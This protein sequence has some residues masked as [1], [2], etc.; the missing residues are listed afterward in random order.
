MHRALESQ[1][2][3]YHC[4]FYSP[5]LEYFPPALIA[6]RK[7]AAPIVH[8]APDHAVMYTPT[9]STLVLTFHNYY[10]DPEVQAYSTLAQRVHYRTDLRLLTKLAVRRANIVTAVSQFIADIVRDDL[11]FAGGIRVIPNG[12]DLARFKANRSP[13]EGIRVLFCGNLSARKGADLLKPISS[14][15]DSGIEIWVASGLRGAASSYDFGPNV[16]LIGRI[17]YDEMPALYNETDIFLAPTRR[18]GF[19]LGVA[20]AMASGLPVVATNCSALPELVTPSLGGYLVEPN[21]V[22]EF[23]ARINFLA[24]NAEARLAMGRFNR[25][26]AL[27]HFDERAMIASYEHLFMHARSA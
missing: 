16:K 21:N 15:L 3:D 18:E 24:A 13:H 4:Y 11:G 27:S 1:I 5:T 10:L 6:Q 8:S 12:I 14:M 22:E 17:A 23:A 7:N 26:H 19:G 25:L 9:D 2:A 20:E